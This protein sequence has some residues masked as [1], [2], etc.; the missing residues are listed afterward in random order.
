MPLR[1]RLRVEVALVDWSQ[2]VLRLHLPVETV[3]D[4]ACFGH[5]CCPIDP[6]E[7]FE[8]SMSALPNSAATQHPKRSMR[9][10]KSS[11]ACKERGG[12]TYCARKTKN[13]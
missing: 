8:D 2:A 9:E 6:C 5:G 10:F 12:E 4:V 13:F 7:V 3:C 1:E 11:R